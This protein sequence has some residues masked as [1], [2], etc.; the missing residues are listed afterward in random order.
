MKVYFNKFTSTF[1]VLF[2]NCAKREHA[3]VI[4]SFNWYFWCNHFI[5]FFLY[6]TM[7]NSTWTAIIIPNKYNAVLQDSPKLQLLMNAYQSKPL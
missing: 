5:L 3:I 7:D 2:S 6:L 1:Q 4:T